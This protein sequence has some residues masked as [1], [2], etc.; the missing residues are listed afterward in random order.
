METDDWI[1]QIVFKSQLVIKRIILIIF[2]V[3]ENVFTWQLNLVFT[4]VCD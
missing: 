2:M 4:N 1:E 3:N